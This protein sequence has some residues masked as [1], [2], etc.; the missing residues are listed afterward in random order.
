MPLAVILNLATFGLPVLMLVGLLI[1]VSMLYRHPT[2]PCHEC[3]DRVRLDKRVC[4]NCGYEFAVV[5]T[6]R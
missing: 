2:R 1:A 4:G 6:T 3:G 5:R